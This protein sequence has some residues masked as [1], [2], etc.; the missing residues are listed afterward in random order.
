MKK[1]ISPDRALRVIRLSAITAL[2]G[3]F[4]GIS[5]GFFIYESDLLRALMF[6]PA[7]FALVTAFVCFLAYGVAAY[8]K[9]QN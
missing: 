7:I 5:T 4:I 9:R 3:W 8:K 1:R 6:P 2:I